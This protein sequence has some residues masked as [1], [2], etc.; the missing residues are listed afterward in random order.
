MIDWKRHH[1][2]ICKKLMT[3]EVDVDE[4]LMTKND[5]FLLEE[6]EIVTESEP[7]T[8][9]LK[10]E[11]EKMDEYLSYIKSDDYKKSKV[12]DT[13]S[14]DGLDMS[15]SKENKFFSSFKERISLAPD[16]VLRFQPGGKP[17]SLSPNDQSFH[18][19]PC[20]YCHSQRRFEFQVMPQLLYYLKLDSSPDHTSIDWATL[21]IYTCSSSCTAK[22]DDD[23]SKYM[24][25][26]ILKQTYD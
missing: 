26:F 16:Q 20:P 12:N 18:V 13:L 5:N 11:K 10:M 2:G 9:P 1:K 3:G 25:E 6:F 17:L 24:E 14:L 22:P 19:P 4:V 23:K 21:M 15:T 8:P 7:A